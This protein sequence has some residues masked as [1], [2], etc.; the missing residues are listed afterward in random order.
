MLKV[1]V[2]LL[3]IFAAAID[4][5]RFKTGIYRVTEKLIQGLI[6]RVDLQLTASGSPDFFS[7]TKEH[8][9]QQQNFK[10]LKLLN[11]VCDDA[12]IYHCVAPHDVVGDEIMHRKGLVRFL[13]VHDMMAFDCPE[14][15]CNTE[16]AYLR[17]QSLHSHKHNSWFF[18]VSGFTKERLCEHLDIDPR[19]VFVTPNGVDEYVFYRTTDDFV[20]KKYNIPK[21]PY[22]LV[23]TRLD[24]RKNIELLVRCFVKVVLQEKLSDLSLVVVGPVGYGHHSLATTL[25]YA[26]KIP[27]LSERIICTDYVPSED[28]AS[29]YSNSM[30]FAYPSLYE[31]FGMPVLEAM[32]CGTPVVASNVAS[33]P[34]VVGD[35]GIL[36]DPEDEDGLSDSIYKIYRDGNLRDM[37]RKKGLE[38]AKKFGWRNFIETTFAGYHKAME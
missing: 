35:S 4:A 20:Y 31:G 29:L 7:L 26:M 16:F 34:E 28:L 32:Q 13:T 38:R 30:M 33:L 15:C 36:I 18:A 22:V 17:K 6:S 5:N 27:E 10:P 23:V 24:P 3:D 14:Y 8:L 37:L 11:Y 9:K 12:D 21:G 2:D 19:R 1:T 25:Q